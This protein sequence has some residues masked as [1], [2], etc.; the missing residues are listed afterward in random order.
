MEG[1]AEKELTGWEK[2]LEV[3]QVSEEVVLVLE[4]KDL[5]GA[6]KQKK[7]WVEVEE[8]SFRSLP[9][10]EEGFQRS[11]IALPRTFP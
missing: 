8:T 10:F 7:L 11:A 1:R 4:V 2:Q 3:P 6:V 5:E 9:F